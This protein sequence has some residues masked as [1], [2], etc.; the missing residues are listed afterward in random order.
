MVIPIDTSKINEHRK[1]DRESKELEL[2]QVEAL[3]LI[4]DT[5]EAIKS[6]FAGFQ[7]DINLITLVLGKLEINFRVCFSHLADKRNRYTTAACPL[8]DK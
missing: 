8:T 6:E 7:Q 5:L 4:A 2:H 3:E 1:S